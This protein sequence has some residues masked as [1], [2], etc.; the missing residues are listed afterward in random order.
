[1]DK[2]P[3][4]WTIRENRTVEKNE[5]DHSILEYIKMFANLIRITLVWFDIK[6]KK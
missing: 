1:M 3:P 2:E 5:T 6:D 4:D